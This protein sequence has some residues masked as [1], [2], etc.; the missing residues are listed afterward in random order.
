MIVAQDNDRA[1]EEIIPASRGTYCKWA[2]GVFLFAAVFFTCGFLFGRVLPK[3]DVTADTVER[4]IRTV[5]SEYYYYEDET[6]QDL[7][8]G[9]LKGM[10]SYLDDPYAAYYTA[11]EYAALLKSESGSYVGIGILIRTDENGE[12]IIS[13]VYGNAPAALAGLHTGDV[14]MR[15]NGTGTAGLDTDAVTD[16]FHCEDKA[17]NTVTVRRGEELLTFSVT[18][19]EVYTPYTHSRMLDGHIGYIHISGFHGKVV[20]E[21]KTAVA[22]L[23]EQGMIALVLDVRDDPGGTLTDVC[24]I[25]DIFLPKGCVITSLMGRGGKEEKYRTSAEG[26]SL[27]IAMLVN[28]RSASASELLAGALHDNG[29]AV[30]F[31]TQTYGKGIVQSYFELNDGSTFKMTT[32]AYFTP[33]GVCIQGKGI[34]PDHTVEMPEEI[35]YVNIYELTPEEDPQLGAALAYLQSL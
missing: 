24:D 1:E 29:A 19:G 25:A 35:E 2:A 15:V 12:F 13:A 27:P 14:L 18:A 11:E 5:R 10:A 17:E 22:E 16:L 9:A 3:K 26:L 33:D 23:L 4:V 7:R 8:T 30:L 6:E 20:G 32:E 21:M 31:G 34:T 28:E